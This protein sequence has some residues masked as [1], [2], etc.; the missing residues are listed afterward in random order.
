MKVR[1]RITPYYLHHKNCYST[2]TYRAQIIKSMHTGTIDA[3]YLG[4]RRIKEIAKHGYINACIQKQF[5]N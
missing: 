2:D 3:C 1:I 4:T 5:I